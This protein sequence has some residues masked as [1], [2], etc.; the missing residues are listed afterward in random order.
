MECSVPISH[1]NAVDVRPLIQWNNKM[2]EYLKRMEGVQRENW[3]V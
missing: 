2:K 1:V 3:N